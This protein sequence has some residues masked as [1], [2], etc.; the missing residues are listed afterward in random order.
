MSSLPLM[1]STSTENDLFWGT[2]SVATGTLGW[3]IVVPISGSSWIPPQML[4]RSTC[5]AEPFPW[6]LTNW[7]EAGLTAVNSVSLR[8][9]VFPFFLPILRSLFAAVAAKTSE[10]YFPTSKSHLFN[11]EKF[12]WLSELETSSSLPRSV[13]GLKSRI[14]S[15]KVWWAV[16]FKSYLLNSPHK[17]VLFFTPF[18]LH[19]A[20]FSALNSLQSRS[21]CR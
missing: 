13:S 3:A 14:L 6:D 10:M 16:L 17:R 2:L 4:T 19:R 9:L 8:T 7:E 5:T 20:L 21:C 11:S 1:M 18:V 12:S 15:C